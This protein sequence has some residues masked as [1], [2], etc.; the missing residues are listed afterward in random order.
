MKGNLYFK[1]QKK[2]HENEYKSDQ[3]LISDSN[4]EAIEQND[5]YAKLKT[6]IARYYGEDNPTIKCRNCK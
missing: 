3:D 5:D 6:Q 1:G 4:E 2:Q